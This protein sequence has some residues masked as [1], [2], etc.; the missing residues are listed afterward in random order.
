M[1]HR[2]EA[3]LILGEARDA[4]LERLAERV[5]EC[6]EGILEDAQGE[7]FMSEIEA[8]YDE[9]GG[10]LVKVSEMLGSIPAPDDE[11]ENETADAIR[12]NGE[13]SATSNQ[14]DVVNFGTFMTEIN[15]GNIAGA[16][17]AL[18]EILNVSEE[19]GL[20][21]AGVFRSGLE[22]DAEF[23]PVAMKLRAAV[24]SGSANE[25][26]FLLAKCFGL[27]G[28]ELADALEFLRTQAIA[29]GQ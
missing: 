15:S 18:A 5:V 10:R 22:A 27:Q 1:T 25:A 8:V 2:T 14:P 26:M 11:G 28:L 20:E 19:R 23:L 13:S 21:C 9:I 17:S 16:G 6:R 12:N 29:T 4:L 3:I 7:S 24:T